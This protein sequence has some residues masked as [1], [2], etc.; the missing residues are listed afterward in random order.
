MT[1]SWCLY[2]SYNRLGKIW[3]KKKKWKYWVQPM[4][5]QKRPF[6]TLFFIFRA[7]G[8]VWSVATLD[9]ADTS[10]L[11]LK[12]WFKVFST[13]TKF[14]LKS[15]NIWCFYIHLFPFKLISDYNFRH[16]QETQHTY[17]LELGTQRVWDYAGGT[18]NYFGE[19]SL[20]KSWSIVLGC[21]SS[22][23]A[24]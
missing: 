21:V 7:Y 10:V 23:H 2:I 20:K 6:A 22:P 24:Q 3:G 5:I 15:W 11:T 9:V 13:E 19:F 16:Y 17:S 12:G 18:V 8:F 14:T 1:E 4:W